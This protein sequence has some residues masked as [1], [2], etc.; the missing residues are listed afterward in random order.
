MRSWWSEPQSAPGL[1]FLLTVYSFSIFN[2]KE[3]NQFDFGID[4]LVMSMWKSSLV[5]LKE[6]VCY[7]HCILFAE[8]SSLTRDQT[9]APIPGS[10][11]A[12]PQD[13]QGSPNNVSFF[14]LAVTLRRIYPSMVFAQKL[15]MQVSLL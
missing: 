8:F 12:S 2:Y 11:E 7:D 10:L 15:N 3:W 6:S 1:Q 14:N 9:H 5:L 13:H 4:Y